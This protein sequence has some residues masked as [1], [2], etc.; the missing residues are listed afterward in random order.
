M[1]EKHIHTYRTLL[2]SSGDIYLRTLED[3]HAAMES[4]LHQQADSEEVDMAAFFYSVMRLPNCIDRVKRVVM[5][6]NEEAFRKN[7]L[8]NI[9]HWQQVSA[10][11]RRRLMLFD[12]KETLAMFVNSA[13][14]IDDIVPSLTAFQMEWNKMHA[15][16][17]EATLRNDLVGGTVK[18]ET[19]KDELKKAL[20]LSTDDWGLLHRVWGECWNE[21]IAAIALGPKNIRVKRLACG[22]SDY[23]RAVQNWWNELIRRFE[24]TLIE[25]RPVYFVS[26][27]M[28]SMANVFSGFATRHCEA[29]LAHVLENDKKELQWRLQLLEADEWEGSR[30]NFLYYGVRDYIEEK[31]EHMAVMRAMEKEVGILR[32][33]HSPFL[34]IHAQIIDLRKLQ[35]ERMD[36]R[37]SCKELEMLKHSRALILNVNYPLGLAAYHLLSQVVSSVTKL[38]GIYIMGKVATLSGRPGDIVIPNEVYDAHSRNVFFFKN[39]FSVKHLAK[40]L[41]ESAVFDNQKSATVLGTFLHNQK[42]MESFHMDGY[43]E[44]EMEAGPYLCAIYEDLYPE[45][46]PLKTSINLQVDDAYDIGILHYV[47]DTPYSK[48]KSLLSDRLGFTGIEATYACTIAILRRIFERE[49][50]R[51]QEEQNDG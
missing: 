6:Q 9:F 15:R 39:C 2:R 40:Y 47:S 41:R 11:A 45:R 20:G 49:I 44:I 8:D 4:N 36:T 18:A 3:S 29:I 25:F 26:S 17:A 30:E 5:G 19:V 22:F 37:L 48:R 51:V 35:P 21:K 43:D 33:E 50:Q 32:Y 16:L 13:S 14:D 31:K 1:I 28:H 23:M 34:D 10:R 12:G 38:R 24:E 42:M 27:N 46:Y 7:D